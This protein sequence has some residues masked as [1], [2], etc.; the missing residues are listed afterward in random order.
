[1]PDY[2]VSFMFNSGKSG[3]SEQWFISA[4]N[5]DNAIAQLQGDAFWR[6]FMAPRAVGAVMT[7]IRVNNVLQPRDSRLIVQR[8]QR[9]QVGT[10]TDKFGEEPGVC[11]L[12]YGRTNANHHRAVMV[13]GL[14]DL[15]IERD[16]A[17]N[18]KWTAELLDALDLYR[19][20]IINARLCSRVLLDATI[21]NP[22][23]KLSSMKPSP[24]GEGMTQFTYEG[25]YELTDFQP[26]VIHGLPRSRFP[27]YQGLLP[28]RNVTT[29]TFDVPVPYRFQG[30]AQGLSQAT[31]RNAF[32]QLEPIVSIEWVDM[33]TR[34]LGRPFFSPRGRRS[35][36]K[37]RSH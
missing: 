26:V 11:A 36:V 20:S 12:G 34:K 37:Y 14:M 23:Q 25:T 18:V 28:I 8:W 24:N 7:A 35:G 13:R 10:S 29:N 6:N 16:A 1:M 22:D 21:P 17:D 30:V 5:A 4:T 3:F 31:V 9:V 15:Q 19:K 33:R 2:R 27:G 32:F